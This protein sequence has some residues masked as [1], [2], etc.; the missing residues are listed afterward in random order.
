MYHIFFFLLPQRSLC[1]EDPQHFEQYMEPTT[2]LYLHGSRQ[3]LL[4]AQDG[5]THSNTDTGPHRAWRIMQCCTRP[6]SSAV[7][8]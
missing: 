5:F 8:K 7:R 2:M 3:D 1:G 4:T 6:A